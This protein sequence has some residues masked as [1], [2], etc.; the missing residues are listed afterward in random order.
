MAIHTTYW[1]PA[2]SDTPVQLSPQVLAGSVV[3]DL[4]DMGDPID[5][6]VV[7]W[8]P[9]TDSKPLRAGDL[10]H[11]GVYSAR[12]GIVLPIFSRC[13]S[14]AALRTEVQAIDRLFAPTK[15]LGE[16]TV[17]SDSVTWACQCYRTSFQAFRP[18]PVGGEGAIGELAI[19]QLLTVVRLAAPTPW[20]FKALVD[21]RNNA[22]PTSGY[23]STYNNPSPVEVGVHIEATASTGST[24]FHMTNNTTGRDLLV[25]DIFSSGQVLTIDWYGTSDEALS[26]NLHT[27]PS[28]DEDQMGNLN[29]QA[30]LM[31]D[32]GDNSI[33]FASDGTWIIEFSIRERQTSP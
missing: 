6:G 29:T 5:L 14:L 32:P 18:A 8:I 30:D 3:R 17:V 11:G 4:Y 9:F 24:Y 13:G 20:W 21:L 2:G 12:S 7:G 15:G 28:T 33:T 26:A 27:D 1:R 16:L 23:T 25:D 10:Y 22:A 31:L 19:G